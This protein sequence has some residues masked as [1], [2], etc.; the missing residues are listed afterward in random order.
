MV[1]C[2]F[3]CYLLILVR[4]LLVSHISRKIKAFQTYSAVFTKLVLEIRRG[5]DDN[6]CQFSSNK[7][8]RG[9]EGKLVEELEEAG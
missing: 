3:N 5:T 6:V 9:K 4:N 7:S 1:K 8:K 2:Y